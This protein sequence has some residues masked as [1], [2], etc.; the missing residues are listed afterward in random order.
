MTITN[1][2]FG[3][4]SGIR[5]FLIES[6]LGALGAVITVFLCILADAIIISDASRLISNTYFQY[7]EILVL[8]IFGAVGARFFARIFV[9]RDSKV[10]VSSGFI[11]T[12]LLI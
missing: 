10:S 4:K 2:W 8:P 12:I 7:C 11:T 5:K 3:Q 9:H 1:N 6:S